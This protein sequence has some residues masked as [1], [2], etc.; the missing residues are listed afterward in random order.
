ME[1]QVVN[2]IVKIGVALI[3]DYNRQSIIVIDQ[4]NSYFFFFFLIDRNFIFNRYHRALSTG[5]MLHVCIKFEYIPLFYS[6]TLEQR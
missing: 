1:L 4:C 3:D 5:Q 6:I 2:D